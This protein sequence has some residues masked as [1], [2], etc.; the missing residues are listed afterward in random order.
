MVSGFHRDSLT[1]IC[2]F[3]GSCSLMGGNTVV[4]CVPLDGPAHRVTSVLG[5][6]CWLG[7]LYP[8][9]VCTLLVE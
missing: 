2:A 3:E 9:L 4:M 6:Q 5:A 8:T 7:L 1:S